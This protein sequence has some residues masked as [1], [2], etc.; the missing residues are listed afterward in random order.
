MA[1][2]IAYDII[3]VSML[4]MPGL[5][6]VKSETILSWIRVIVLL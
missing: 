1:L 2:L 5:G 6:I 4:S 3:P